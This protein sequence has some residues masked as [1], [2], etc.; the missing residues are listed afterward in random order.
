MSSALP[1]F[2]LPRLR[3]LESLEAQRES[4]SARIQTL[5][6]HSHKR[7][8]LQKRLED[9]TLAALRAEVQIEAEA[10]LDARTR[11]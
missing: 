1:L 7:V 9:L 4:L 5:P 10:E 3:A 6:L 2:D 11:P 8:V